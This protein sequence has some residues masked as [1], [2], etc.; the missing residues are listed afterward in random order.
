MRS[1]QTQPKGGIAMSIFEAFILV[2]TAMTFIVTL[3][4][5]MIALIDHFSKK[6]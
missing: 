1:P 2:F 6:K 3:V 5:L 4:K